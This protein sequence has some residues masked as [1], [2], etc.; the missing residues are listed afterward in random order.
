MKKLILVLIVIA[1]FPLMSFD[2]PA[3]DLFPTVL[4][5]TVR[6]ELGNPVEGA[7]VT[8]YKKESDY[9][10]GENPAYEPQKTDEK[11]RVK[12]RKI[13]ATTY[14]VDAQKGDKS[15]EAGGVE[16]QRL[17]DGKV[18]RITIVIM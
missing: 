12:F 5:I 15:N 3:S 6:N 9:I 11:G 18:N 2:N 4:K 8:L 10:K 7:T 1:T 16:T 14:F 17:D 13:D